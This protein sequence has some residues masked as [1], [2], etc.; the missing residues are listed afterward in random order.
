MTLVKKIYMEGKSMGWPGLWQEVKDICKEI[1][2]LDVNEEPVS[3]AEIKNAIKKSV[4]R[5]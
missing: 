5:N 4:L 2:I 1:G 3:K